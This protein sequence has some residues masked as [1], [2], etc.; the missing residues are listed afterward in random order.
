MAY[1]I[2]N[3]ITNA[4]GKELIKHGTPAFPIACY[5]VRDSIPFHWHDEMECGVVTQGQILISAGSEKILLKE[6]DGFFINSGILH[7]AWNEDSS[8]NCF[9]SIVF[10]PRLVGDNIE[11]IFWQNY[12]QPLLSNPSLQVIILHRN[13]DCYL[14]CIHLI[15]NAWASCINEKYG[16]EFEARNDLSQL[17]SIINSYCPSKAHEPTEKEIRN[18]LRIKKM[19]IYIHE[20]Y[21]EEI[22]IENISKSISVSPSECLRCFHNTIGTTPIQYVKQYRIQ[23]SIDLL[24]NSHMKV[25]EIGY[26][27]GFQEMSYFAKAFRDIKGCTPSEYRKTTS[28]SSK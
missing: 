19:L 10:H 21:F 4:Q 1:S 8:T 28:S 22:T 23:K 26:E 2:C 3:I 6:G 5:Y 18:N 12:I 17:I 16:Y 20:H 27:C 9:H 24:D 11:S 14:K 15:E 25:S 13:N 7:A